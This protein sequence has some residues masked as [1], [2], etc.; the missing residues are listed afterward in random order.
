MKPH[1]KHI[2]SRLK[3][4][5]LTRE[6]YDLSSF[7]DFLIIGPQRTGTTWLHG[8][9]VEHPEIFMPTE[10]E[11]YY[12]NS[13][14]DP[15]THP[16]RWGE[17]SSDLD[18]YLDFFTPSQALREELEQQCLERFNEPYRP[19][20]VGEGTATYAAGLSGDVIDE[21]LVLNPDIKIITM[22]RDPVQRAWSHAKKDLSKLA[23][24][25]Q[26][27]IPESEWIEFFSRWYQVRCGHPSHYMPLWKDRVPED[28]LFI[29][30]FIDVGER[31]GELLQSV[32][33]FLGISDD[34][35]YVGESAQRRIN[36]TD[37]SEIPPNLKEHLDE[38]FSAEVQLLHDHGLI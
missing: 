31:P 7:P 17:V 4:V 27:T 15:S 5:T 20:M 13:L 23:G 8:N 22:V 25:A 36:P 33:R 35:K 6:D 21:I 30:R 2:K 32:Y 16:A 3:L 18:W 11:L 12:F 26:D 10:K 1:F 34:I 38:L 37:N 28:N 19:S 29:G 14:K 24:R 9:L